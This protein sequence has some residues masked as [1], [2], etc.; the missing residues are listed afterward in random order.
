MDAGRLTA[1]SRADRTTTR[2]VGKSIG[3]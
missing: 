2:R 1:E 3:R